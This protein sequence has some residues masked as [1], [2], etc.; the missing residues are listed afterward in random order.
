[1][2]VSRLF[3]VKYQYKPKNYLLSEEEVEQSLYDTVHLTKKE[4]IEPFLGKNSLPNDGWKI[5]DFHKEYSRQG[6]R[7]SDNKFRLV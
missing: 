1:M 5:Y 6:V 2:L 7:K 4:S 3:V